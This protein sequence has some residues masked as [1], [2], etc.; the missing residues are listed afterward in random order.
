MVSVFVSI[1][2]LFV[3]FNYKDLLTSV[4]LYVARLIIIFSGLS[5][6]ITFSIGMAL[7][8]KISLDMF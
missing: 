6:R 3:N 2:Y 1:V 7:L 4:Q 5:C 8:N